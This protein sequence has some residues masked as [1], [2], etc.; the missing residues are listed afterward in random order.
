M[1]NGQVKEVC[2]EG[3]SLFAPV[4][5]R[6]DNEVVARKLILPVIMAREFANT[7]WQM[8]GQRQCKSGRHL[9]LWLD[10]RG[11]EFK[12][13]DDKFQIEIL[14]FSR[15]HKAVGTAILRNRSLAYLPEA[16][17]RPHIE[18]SIVGF[19]DL[20]STALY[21]FVSAN[22][23]GELRDMK[24]ALGRLNV[25]EVPDVS[26]I[27][28]KTDELGAHI[29]RIG[30]FCTY[31]PAGS[32]FLAPSLLYGRTALEKRY[33]DLVDKSDKDGNI[34]GLTEDDLLDFHLFWW[35]MK[36]EE[37]EVVQRLKRGLQAVDGYSMAKTL[38][39]R[40]VER[41]KEVRANTN[42]RLAL[43][44]E[45]TRQ[46]EQA[47]KSWFQGASPSAQISPLPLALAQPL[48]DPTPPA[49]ED[50]PMGF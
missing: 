18:E 49:I 8:Q 30:N 6:P 26:S 37:V 44:L 31:S 20:E 45:N 41:A 50:A 28:Q 32:S 1:Q 17:G 47:V 14:F 38:E 15:L 35:L 40:A 4:P 33:Q 42:K 39:K 16:E 24:E 12:S 3:D 11:N 2:G 34:P 7:A 9:E 36:A 48:S 46:K 29:E 19:A 5:Y 27:L 13:K 22:A 21:K 10:A 43:S 25:K 23:Q